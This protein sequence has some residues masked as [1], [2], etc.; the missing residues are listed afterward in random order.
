MRNI[1]Q[2]IDFSHMYTDACLV[3]IL[4]GVLNLFIYFFFYFIKLP[5]VDFVGILTG[6][7]NL[8]VF[9]DGRLVGH[10]G[11]FWNDPRW[12]SFSGKTKVIAVSINNG[13]GFVGF[14]GVFSN[15]VVT[16]SSWKCK[17][18]DSPEYGWEQANFTD[19]AWPHALIRQDNSGWRK[20]PRVRGIPLNVHWISPANHYANR[21]ICRR[22]FSTEERKRN[23]SK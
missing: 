12:F 7:D 4:W 23:R 13:P 21:V 2:W 10:N 3:Q 6:D 16:D 17:E 19:D 18:T 8:T 15:E 14:L 11:G 20:L 22:H 5:L 9:A 1:I